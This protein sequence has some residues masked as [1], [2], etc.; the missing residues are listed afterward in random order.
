MVELLPPGPGAALTLH[1]AG[2]SQ[3]MGQSL[4]K[5]TFDIENVEGFRHEA[6]AK[7]LDCG[8][9]HRGDGYCFA[10]AK[11]PSGNSICISSA[12]F[13]AGKAGLRLPP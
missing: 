11:D 5:L 10:N 3:K 7:G 12:A 13:A 1:P 6:K 2:K 4:V 9:I 8:A